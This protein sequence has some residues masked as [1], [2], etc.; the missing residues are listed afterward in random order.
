MNPT[1]VAKFVIGGT[2][3]VQRLVDMLLDSVHLPTHFY[4]SDL[5]DENSPAVFNGVTVMLASPQPARTKEFL[6]KEFSVSYCMPVCTLDEIQRMRTAVFPHVS[7]SEATQLFCVYGGIPRSVLQF[8]YRGRQSMDSALTKTSD[9]AKLMEFVETNAYTSSPLVRLVPDPDDFTCSTLHWASE[10]VVNEVL[11]SCQAAVLADLK[12]IFLYANSFYPAVTLRVWLFEGFAHVQL[13]RGAVEIMLALPLI[14][15]IKRAFPQ[16]NSK[17]PV[18]VPSGTGLHTLNP[19]IYYRPAKRN[20]ES[21]DAFAKVGQELFSFQ[22]TVA[23]KHPVKSQGLLD[24]ITTFGHD[25]T[26][27]H[28]VFVVPQSA[29]LESATFGAQHIIAQEKAGSNPLPMELSEQR[30]KQWV[31]QFP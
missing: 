16:L 20:L 30:F 4:F 19:S 1:V 21:V 13:A 6:K 11:R 12:R 7:A 9:Y 18:I 14:S 24:I 15:D 31:C 2:V 27:T 25:C 28:L 22:I 23:S 29:Q 3:V 5:A 10:Y 26:V 17:E 8:A